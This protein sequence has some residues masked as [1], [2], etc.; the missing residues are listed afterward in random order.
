M[1][2]K[3]TTDMKTETKEKAP[4]EAKKLKS[5]YDVI[6]VGGG[7]SGSTAAAYLGKAG[8]DV[9][10]VDRAKFP[11]DK[12]CGDG[13]SGKSVHVLQELGLTDTI[14]DIEHLDMYGV[15]FSSP[16]GT[17]IEIDSAPKGTKE[18]PGYVCRREIFDNFLFQNMKKYATTI[19]QFF[20][21]DL[22]REGDKVVGISGTN[23]ATKEKMT[24]KAKVVVCAD[25]AGGITIRKLNVVNTK[26][27][28]QVSALRAYYDNVEGMN[29]KIELHFVK[30]A[31]PGYFWIF[32]LP[33]KTANVGIGMLVS[34][35]KKKGMNLEKLMYDIIEKHPMF[36]DRFKN[37]K[38]IS[39]V[40]RWHLPLGSW[41]PK[42]Y[43]NGYVLVGDTASLIDPFTGEG[44]G[45]ALISGKI[46]SK[47]IMKAFE[48]NDFSENVLGEYQKALYDEV[49][50][51]LKTS[52]NLQR[53]GTH[54]WLL[55]WLVDKAARSEKVRE[56]ISASLIN[57]EAQK[58]FQNP[59][60]YLKILLA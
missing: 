6:I 32:P 48:K 27:E 2:A 20:V 54:T 29:N 53:L 49:G 52:Y 26:E 37:S 33:N 43:G 21:D 24:F 25:G 40:K 56:A 50:D 38:K 41:R 13:I 39:E 18:P 51:E 31:L 42:T 11:R 44:I 14:K 16:N 1:V 57:P 19:E 58:Q 5:E 59:L 46:A 22:I 45:N 34:D 3:K 36:K 17:V 28:H 10:L 55:N 47:I 35:M 23:M 15:T 30:E 8:K 12:T 4:V 60:F 9:L 7:P